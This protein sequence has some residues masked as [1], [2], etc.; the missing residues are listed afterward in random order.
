MFGNERPKPWEA[1][2]LAFGVVGLYQP[3]AVEEGADTGFQGRFLLFIIHPRHD[4]QR[5]PPRPQFVGLAVVAPR[6]G[7]VVAGVGVTQASALW[8]EEDRKSTRL[9]SSH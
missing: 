8:I 3:I 4:P 2:H 7:E 5:H 9:N 1:E 6:A